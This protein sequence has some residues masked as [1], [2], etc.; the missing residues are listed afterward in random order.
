MEHRAW[1]REQKPKTKKKN[2]YAMPHALC[3]LQEVFM[4]RIV[5]IDYGMGNLK[6]V[7]KGFEWIGFEAEVTRDKKEIE[8]ASAIVLPEVGAFKDCMENLEKYGL[9]ERILR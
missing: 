3:P 4:S 2:F 8:R 7:Q 1:S 6:N 9:V 5:I